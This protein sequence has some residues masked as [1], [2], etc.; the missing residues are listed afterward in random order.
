VDEDT[1]FRRRREPVTLLDV[2]AGLGIRA[3]GHLV[4]GV[5]V[6]ATVVVFEVKGMEPWLEGGAGS[7]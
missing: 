3:E 7:R 5:F 4:Q 1:S 2:K 6:A